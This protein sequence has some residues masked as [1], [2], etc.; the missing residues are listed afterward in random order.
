MKDTENLSEAKRICEMELQ[1]IPSEDRRPLAKSYGSLGLICQKTGHFPDAL[2]H[3]ER[4]LE[5]L[6]ASSPADDRSIPPA[7]FAVA[8]PLRK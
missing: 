6:L 3:Y 1:R 2:T 7:Y 5:N 4:S 8:A